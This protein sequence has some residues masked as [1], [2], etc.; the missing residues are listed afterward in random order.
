MVA[1]NLPKVAPRLTTFYREEKVIAL[2]KQ[3]ESIADQ[4]LKDR[5][6]IES[7]YITQMEADRAHALIEIAQIKEQARQDGLKAGKEEAYQ[8]FSAVFDHVEAVKMEFIAQ[9]KGWAEEAEAD[10]VKLTLVIAEKLLQQE[11]ATH[12][13][14]IVGM[15]KAILKETSENQRLTLQVNPEDLSLIHTHLPELKQTLGAVKIFEAESNPSIP[16]GGVVFDMDSGMLDAR[17][18]TQMAKLYQSLVNDPA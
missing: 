8:A 2:L 13:D 12:P 1:R 14:L 11:L 5:S 3:A 15:I 4:L 17:I 6:R 16:R 7:E 10:I 9:R 18:E